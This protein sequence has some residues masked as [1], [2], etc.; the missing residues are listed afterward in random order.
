MHLPRKEAGH[1]EITM[2]PL[3]ILY[4]FGVLYIIYITLSNTRECY[5]LKTWNLSRMFSE[6]KDLQKELNYIK[7]KNNVPDFGQL[8]IKELEY[9]ICSR[10]AHEFSN[11]CQSCICFNDKIE[12]QVAKIQHL[13]ESQNQ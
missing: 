5:Y 1:S 4:L 6:W 8:Y 13:V 11:Q 3:I 7:N 10:R 12:R 2:I 9:L